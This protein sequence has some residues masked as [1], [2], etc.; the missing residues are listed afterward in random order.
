MLQ[1]L[2]RRRGWSLAAAIALLVALAAVLVVALR[3]SSGEGDSPVRRKPAARLPALP[4]AWS[5]DLADGSKPLPIDPLD[6]TPSGELRTWMA[7]DTL[8]ML[9]TRRLTAYDVDTG[10]RRWT[11]RPPSGTTRVCGA[12]RA[13]DSAGLAGLILSS[14]GTCRVV[15][16]IDVRTG[17]LRWRRDLGRRWSHSANDAD[18]YVGDRTVAVPLDYRG[19]R[20][21]DL[22]TGRPVEAKP[23]PS[24]S[25]RAVVGDG[26][27][28]LSSFGGSRDQSIAVYDVDARRLVS[29]TPVTETTEAEGIVSADP[30][31]LDL[32]GRGARVY[33]RV[34]RG[35]RLGRYVGKSFDGEPQLQ[36][37][38]GDTVVVSYETTNPL[39]RT[40]RYYGFDVATG[41]QRWTTNPDR[42]FILGRRGEDLLTASLGGP[43]IAGVIGEGP[44]GE[45]TTVFVLGQTPAQDPSRQALLGTV[46]V[47]GTWGVDFDPGWNGDVFLVQTDDT[48]A[49]YRLPQ[50]GKTPLPVP[51][52]R[53]DWADGDVRTEQAVDLCEAVRPSTLRSLGFHDLRVPPPAG[54]LWL[55]TFAPVGALRRLTVSA[56]ALAPGKNVPGVELARQRLADLRYDEIDRLRADTRYPGIGDEAWWGQDRRHG[57]DR[58]RLL[59]RYRN[60]IV[61]ADSSYGGIRRAPHPTGQA[62]LRLQAKVI[63]DVLAR[64][65]TLG[66]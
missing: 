21:F 46:K 25:A 37:V 6:S 60:L 22:S 66:G 31:V 2:A 34:D 64:A 24:P 27:L 61:I 53:V 39:I 35:G 3:G 42:T 65:R 40:A 49:A 36:G 62:W 63:E 59:V 10:A 51:E 29:R 8:V 11:R 7:G 56:I 19:Y 57:D 43:G 18:L 41:K 32:R 16:L 54:C 17:K 44:A 48:L 38:L 26:L 33:R 20:L 47:N 45:D 52:E 15:A 50:P 13:P 5:A 9:G 1:S 14:R 30:L 23:V 12:S 4:K 28:V 58:S 55:E